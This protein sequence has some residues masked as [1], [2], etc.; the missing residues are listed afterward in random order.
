MKA[1]IS[2]LV[3][4][5]AAGAPLGRAASAP[6]A[7]A[8]A[9]VAQAERYAADW[10][11]PTRGHEPITLFHEAAEKL[12]AELAQHPNDVSLRLALARAL[13]GAGQYRLARVE[14]EKIPVQ[15]RPVAARGLQA[16][17][18]ARDQIRGWVEQRNGDTLLTARPVGDGL[19]LAAAGKTKPAIL[20]GRT[21]ER[22]RLL[23]LR[24]GE[25]VA[26]QQTLPL[27]GPENHRAE[28]GMYTLAPD[29][30]PVDDHEAVLSRVELLVRRSGGRVLLFVSQE[31]RGA[32]WQPREVQAY[33]LSGGRLRWML[34]SGSYG[35]PLIRDEDGDGQPEL[36]SFRAV[37]WRIPTMSRP[38]YEET[39]EW[40]GSRWQDAS[41]KFP[42]RYHRLAAKLSAA[43]GKSA[44]DPDLLLFLA[45]SLTAEGHDAEGRQ[46]A[47]E[48]QYA[49]DHWPHP[50]P[51]AE[52]RKEMTALIQRYFPSVSAP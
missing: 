31:I 5:L 41:R 33:L 37:G 17:L 27:A 25:R 22:A 9:F 3:V 29:P 32:S 36:V 34:T 40:T 1:L 42:E 14:L 12:R 21:I 11:D 2:S 44:A 18:E 48:A 52:D 10:D 49:T 19:W 39:F 28:M 13:S 8:V 51:D 45:R 4:G 20:G 47:A 38:L 30:E 16:E 24:V 23:L 15:S 7:S 43:A 26:V 46:R 50:Q 35:R 6:P